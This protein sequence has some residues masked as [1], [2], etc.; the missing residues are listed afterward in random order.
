MAARGKALGGASHST[1]SD[2]RIAASK[3][4]EKGR[5]CIRSIG[6]EVARHRTASRGGVPQSGARRKAAQSRTKERKH[7]TMRGASSI[8]REAIAPR[9]TPSDST[10]A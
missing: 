5:D 7:M 1:S 3:L 10:M 8:A 6:Q 2:D 4:F 9:P